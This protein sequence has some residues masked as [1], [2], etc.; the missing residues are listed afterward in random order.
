MLAGEELNPETSE[1]FMSFMFSITE[2]V[3]LS[4]PGKT[5]KR[6]FRTDLELSLQEQ[7][8]PLQHHHHPQ[9]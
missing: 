7:D 2:T 1:T 5:L 4:C 8:S 9:N 6:D 3:S